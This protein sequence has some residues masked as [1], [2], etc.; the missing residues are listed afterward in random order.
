MDRIITK[1]S[2]VDI[3]SQYGCKSI[4]GYDNSKTMKGEKRGYT[5][6]I[7]YLTPN[8]NLCPMS[9][10]AGCFEGCLVTSGLAGVYQSIGKTRT[11]RTKFFENDR[12]NFVRLLKMEI[13]AFVNRATRNKV[14]PV[15]RLNGTS[16]I[17]WARIQVSNGKNIFEVFPNIIFYDYTKRL[18]IIRDSQDIPN[19][20]VTASYSEANQSY[21]ANT[22]ANAEEFGVNVAVVFSGE[23]PKV[24]KGRKVINGDLDDLRFLDESNVIVGLSAKGKAKMDKSGFVIKVEN[25][26]AS[27]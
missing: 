16:D 26:I 6:A 9:K 13:T 8:T 27:S 23:L 14:T 2:L 25:L 12:E 10:R 1:K 24:F 11:G 15:V 7:A 20:H 19:W 3:A 22:L 4:L 5:T 18:D 17:N 21:A